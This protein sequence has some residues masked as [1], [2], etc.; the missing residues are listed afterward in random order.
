MFKQT[1]NKISWA[2]K[3][4]LL[5][6]SVLIFSAC[7]D[8]TVEPPPTEP[9]KPDSVATLYAGQTGDNEITVLWKRSP[10]ESQ[11][12]F[13]YYQVEILDGSNSVA[14]VTVPK[15]SGDAY[16]TF[17]N[18]VLSKEYEFRVWIVANVINEGETAYARGPASIT[19]WATAKH[20]TKNY[21]N[22]SIKVYLKEASYGSGLELYGEDSYPVT[23][24][25]SSGAKWNL[26]VGSKSDVIIGTAS[27]VASKVSF[28]LTGTPNDATITDPLNDDFDNL[29]STLLDRG[30]DKLVF[31]KSYINLINF[32]NRTKGLA[33]F[34]KIGNNYA[35]VVVIKNGSSWIHDASSADPYILL[36]VSYQTAAGIPYAKIFGY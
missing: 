28:N 12:W 15:G 17:S 14:K 22:A 21:N 10:N 7:E 24:K 29:T 30:L 11:T 35:K 19:K 8:D 6:V 18:A 32:N 31:S 3:W 27:S 5:A 34:A 16:Y 4:L 1:P 26:A 9:V 13:D 36:Q 25:V 2:S 20:F 33:F 23:H